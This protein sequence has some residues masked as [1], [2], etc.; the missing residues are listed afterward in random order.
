MQQSDKISAAFYN[1]IGSS[2]MYEGVNFVRGFKW[3]GMGS[4][5]DLFLGERWVK[6][7]AGEVIDIVPYTAVTGFNYGFPFMDGEKWR[8]AKRRQTTPLTPPSII[9]NVISTS[10]FATRFARRRL[11]YRQDVAYLGGRRRSRLRDRDAHE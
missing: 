10:F 1:S 3:W 8:G 9:S 2:V 7:I 5:G 4:V 11:L 6:P